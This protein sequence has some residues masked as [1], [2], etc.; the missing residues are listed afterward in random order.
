MLAPGSEALVSMAKVSASNV[1]LMLP[2]LNVSRFGLN[3][4][5]IS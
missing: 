1:P 5:D 4:S 2:M 3:S